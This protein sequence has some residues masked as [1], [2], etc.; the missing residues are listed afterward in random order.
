MES[1]ED[2]LRNFDF[3]LNNAT[4]EFVLILL[5]FLIFYYVLNKLVNRFKDHKLF[6]MEE[7][8]PVEETQTLRQVF[9]LL[10]ISA[11][12]IYILASFTI[13]GDDNFYFSLFDFFIST[14]CFLIMKK[15]STR[16]KILVFFLIP[17][18]SISF[19]L[20]NN[21]GILNFFDFAHVF[22]FV[23]V[24]RRYYKKFVEYTENNSLGIAILL[25]Y[26][27]V[28]ISMIATHF[29]ENVN[30]LDAL[31][32]SSNAFTSNGYSVLGSSIPGKVNS[33]LLVWSGYIISGVSTATLTAALL[34]KHFNNI[35]L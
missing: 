16:D 24:I 32:M 19:L 10:I 23:F 22:A 13:F 30:L 9:Y 29:T 18:G 34:M 25:L 14:F 15:E 11:C 35:D 12:F 4:M 26:I 27:I 33:L 17:F 6:N 8:F 1:T 2:I 3:S 31:V 20:V 21:Y 7:Y 28:F 5:A